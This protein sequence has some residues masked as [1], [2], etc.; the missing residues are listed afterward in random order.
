MKT[1]FKDRI[2]LLFLLFRILFPKIPF[3]RAGKLLFFQIFLD[4]R[5]LEAGK[6]KIKDDCLIIWVSTLNS[7]KNFT[8]GHLFRAGWALIEFH[9]ISPQDT[10]S[11]QN[12]Y[13][14]DRKHSLCNTVGMRIL[15]INKTSCLNKLIIRPN[16]NFNKCKAML[17]LHK[18]NAKQ[19]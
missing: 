1:F 9:K 2:F 18:P 13:M 10:Y 6:L 15:R 5:F 7:G 19:C 3:L 16:A 12:S 8:Q 17:M 4:I 14:E 11:G